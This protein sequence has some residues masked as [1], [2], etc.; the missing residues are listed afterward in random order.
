MSFMMHGLTDL[1]ASAL[2]ISLPIMGS[3]L[4]ITITTGILSKAAPQ[5]NLLSEGFPIMMMTAFFILTVLMPDLCDFFFRSFNAGFARLEQFF[6]M[7]G[8]RI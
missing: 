4:L 1:F 2:V 7:L 8:G 3:L 6:L 5:M